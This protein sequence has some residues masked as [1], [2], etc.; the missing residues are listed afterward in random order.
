MPP[1]TTQ[2]SRW[3]RDTRS[4]ES[5]T[6]QIPRSRTSAI[7]TPV[8]RRLLA[9]LRTAAAALFNVFECA[10]E[11]SV[12]RLTLAST[13]GVYG[14]LDDLR[15]VSEE[16]PLHMTAHGNAVATSKKSAELAVSPSRERGVN[17]ISAR[18]PAVRGPRGRNES[19]FFAAPGLIHSAVSG[20]SPPATYADDAIDLIYV[21]DCARAIALLQT[22]AQLTHPT[23]NIGTGR[24]T[25]NAEIV[26]AIK[27]A[28]PGT[29]LPLKPGQ[30]PHS[31]I[32]Y[33]DT[34]RLHTDTGFEPQ[35]NLD[36]TV[37][38][39][40]SWIINHESV[41]PRIGDAITPREEP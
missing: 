24:A 7:R 19:R 27:R 14:G 33:L 29:E 35:Y 17:A 38:D 8:R 39:Y 30:S 6:S 37:A 36:R 25:S 21:K 5:S 23:Y 41:T 15:G 34:T 16:L 4:T 1:T 11:W 26:A 31:T 2:C 9:D 10:I 18:V 40:T 22:A 32:A 20:E 12:R 28:R 13:I 3:A